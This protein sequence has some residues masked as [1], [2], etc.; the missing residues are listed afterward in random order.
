MA[1]KANRISESDLLLPTL[2]I[3]AGKPNG[4][5]PTADL[6]GELEELFQP[7]GEDAAILDG[8]HDTRFSQIVRNMVSHKET[9][10]NII[11]LGYV[12]YDKPGMRI[13]Q[14]GRDFLKAHGG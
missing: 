12:E 3:L 14:A 9:S 8:R 2:K 1:A 13:T 7:E 10:G 5:L 4:Y 11:A 6:I